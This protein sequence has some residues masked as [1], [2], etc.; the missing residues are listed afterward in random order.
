M[1]DSEDHHCANPNK[2]MGLGINYQ[3][4]L[5]S[6]KKTTQ[7]RKEKT[8]KCECDQACMDGTSK[9]Q[10]ALKQNHLDSLNS[11]GEKGD[12]QRGNEPLP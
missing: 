1:V 3:C 2:V 4:P 12:I 7:K 9:S 10:S 5:I 6:Q 11:K 8:I